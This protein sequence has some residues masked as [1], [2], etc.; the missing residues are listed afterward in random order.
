MKKVL[1]LY[2]GLGGN[3]R[4]WSGDIEV[5]AIEYDPKIAAV[6]KDLYPNDT[7]IVADAHQY[8]LDH[9]QE[10]DIIWSSP[11]CQSH[12]SFRKNICCKFRGTKP[13]YPDMRLYQEILLLDN[14]FSGK[15]VVENV[16]PYYESLIE[17]RVFMN[18][19]MFWSNCEIENIS[20][21][22][23][24]LREAQVPQLQAYHDIDLSKYDL[25]GLN[26]RQLLRNMVDKE[27]GKVVFDDLMKA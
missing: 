10:F 12:S 4:L 11:P 24:K 3:R 13:V 25:K 22:K 26:K 14:Y 9:Y 21:P 16:K 17:P 27:L 20:L 1:N 7:V 19:H 23:A 2:S 15:W 5:T 8:L 6:Y 18:R